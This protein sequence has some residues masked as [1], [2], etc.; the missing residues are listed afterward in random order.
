MASGR[1]GGTRSKVSGTIGSEVYSLRRNPDG[2]YTQVVSSKAESVSYS[3]TEKQAAYRMAAA[4][5]EVAMRDLKAIGRISMQSGANASKSLNAFSSIN[6]ARVQDDMV[7]NW[8]G[9]GQFLYPAKGSKLSLGGQFLISSGTLHVLGRVGAYYYDSFPM[10]M[11]E[12]PNQYPADWM[13]SGGTAISLPNDTMTMKEFLEY[14]G[15]TRRDSIVYVNFTNWKYWDESSDPDDPQI[16][17][18]YKYNWFI[19]KFK[20]TIPDAFVVT[21]NNVSEIFEVESNS[22]PIFLSC[23]RT[24]MFGWF[25]KIPFEDLENNIL[26]HAQFDISYINGFKQ[27]GNSQLLPVAN[28]GA[29]DWTDAN[30]S[31]V[32][33][34]WLNESRPSVKPNPFR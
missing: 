26:G 34:S 2:T 9:G 24:R 22:D 18:D 28:G 25:F 1:V 14:S 31:Q 11:R 16:I 20:A 12:K 27:I 13:E 19:L 15:Y 6:L 5:V 21:L 17:D 33:W 8:Y 32:F 29:W 3:N 30:P 10:I 23:E 7:A 4:V